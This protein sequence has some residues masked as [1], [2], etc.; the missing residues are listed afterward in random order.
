MTTSELMPLITKYC[1]ESGICSLEF[2]YM[3]HN[4]QYSYL[5]YMH[6][7]DCKLGI[8]NNNLQCIMP[9]NFQDHNFKFIYVKEL[10]RHET[11]GE[12]LK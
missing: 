6:I 4:G 8:Y 12:L 3:L 2:T 11:L 5:M 9:L 7:D 10:I 1:T